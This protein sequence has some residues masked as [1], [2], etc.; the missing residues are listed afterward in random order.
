MRL[1]YSALET[2]STCN[3]RA[4]KPPAKQPKIQTKNKQTSHKQA[5]KQQASKQQASKSSTLSTLANLTTLLHDFYLFTTIS[6]PLQ[7]LPS[8][9]VPHAKHSAKHH[10]KHIAKH[11]AKHHKPQRRRQHFAFPLGIIV[12]SH[13]PKAAALESAISHYHFHLFFVNT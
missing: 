13:F 5:S 4:K 2:S 8:T 12:T 7:A 10:A 3:F 11:N 9:H 6:P 1:P